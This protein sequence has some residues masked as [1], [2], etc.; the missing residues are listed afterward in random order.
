MKIIL[1]RQAETDMQWESACDAASFTRA[2]RAAMSRGAAPVSVRRS[3]AARYRVYTGTAR[4]SAETAELLFELAEPPVRTPLLDDVPLRAFRDTQK[5]LP[6]GLW[7]A[8]GGVQ[9]ALGSSRQAETRKQT[10]DRARQFLALIEGEDR[11]CVVVSGGLTLLALKALL[12]RRGYCIEGGGLRPEPLERI[13]ATKQSLHCG[14]CHQNC[15][16]SEA[17]CPTGRNK[18]KER[19]V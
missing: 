17:K 4:A 6:L 10:L 5:A 2:V 18:A 19:R 12:R 14:G 3:D 15:L 13:R 16:L 8:M 9:W 11:D 1:V 7:R